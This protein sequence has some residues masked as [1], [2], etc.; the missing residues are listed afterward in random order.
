MTNKLK[1]DWEKEL[2]QRWYLWNRPGA[3]HVFTTCGEE[4]KEFIRNLLVSQKEE[5]KKC[6]EKLAELEHDQWIAWSKNIAETETLN[7]ERLKRW[8][9]LWRPYSELTEAEKDKDREWADAA[10]TII[11]KEGED[12]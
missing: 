11:D 4:I 8:M 3:E 1:E 5:M 7:P 2:D 6:R 12:E 10:L 9:E